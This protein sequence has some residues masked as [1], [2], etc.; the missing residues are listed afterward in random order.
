MDDATFAQLS[1]SATR[2]PTRAPTASRT[3]STRSTSVFTSP[4]TFTLHERKPR[5]CQPAAWRA[6][7]SGASMPTQALNRISRTTAPPSRV[8]MLMPARRAV[9]SRQAISSAALASKNAGS[10]A[11]SVAIIAWMLSA[12]APIMA[13]AKWSRSILKWSAT[14]SFE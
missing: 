2:P 14:D 6:A 1:T 4:P 9:R 5:A 8:A 12:G 3:A 11:S 13:G 10:M 7:S